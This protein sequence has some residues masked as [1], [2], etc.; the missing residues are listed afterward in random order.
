[1]DNNPNMLRDVGQPLSPS[2][3]PQSGTSCLNAIKRIKKTHR[4]SHRVRLVSLVAEVDEEEVPQEHSSKQDTPPH[5]QH[6][7]PPSTTMEDAIARGV[8]AALRRVLIDKEFP[9]IKKHSPQQ[10][11][12]EEKELQQEKVAEKSYERDFFLASQKVAASR[13]DVYSYEYEDGPGP[14]YK[15]LAFDLKC[16][17]KSPW[18]N[19]VIGLLL[20]ELRRRGDQESWS[21]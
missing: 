7:T 8:E 14:D 12:M 9:V 6:D 2:A 20:E 10:R 16:G 17:S 3:K 1:M 13:E 19:K 4:I 5:L 11:K 21:F 18:N 15:D